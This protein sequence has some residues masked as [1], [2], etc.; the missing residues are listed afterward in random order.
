MEVGVALAPTPTPTPTRSPGKGFATWRPH[1]ADP[2][3][4]ITAVSLA[5]AL[6]PHPHPHPNPNPYPNPNPNPTPNPKQVHALLHAC[7]ARALSPIFQHY[8]RSLPTSCVP[9]ARGMSLGQVRVRVRVIGRGL[10]LGLYRARVRVRVRVCGLT[11]PLPLP[12]PL[13]L[14]RTLPISRPPSAVY[15][16]P[17]M[18]W[19]GRRGPL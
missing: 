4:L 2:T 18:L 14:I 3:G 10:G 7:W 16:T 13:P 17:R 12:L 8:C 15:G 11:L 19:A 6:N 9:P 1:L 5:L